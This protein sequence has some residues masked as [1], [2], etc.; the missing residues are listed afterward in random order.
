MGGLTS[1]F[2]EEVSE[3]SY[4][5]SRGREGTSKIEFLLYVSATIYLSFEKSIDKLILVSLPFLLRELIKRRS[6]LRTLKYPFS[7]TLYPLALGL[8]T[9]LFSWTG[10]GDR[11]LVEGLSLTMRS[12]LST[13]LISLYIERVGLIN[14]LKILVDLGIP[15]GIVTLYEYVLLVALTLST[16]LLTLLAARES[17]TLKKLFLKEIWR[18][19]LSSLEM[20][21]YRVRFYLELRLMALEA[22]RLG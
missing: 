21:L 13:L 8:I 20:F 2:V 11:G 9:T 22:R 19:Q 12:S 14:I 15:E 6:R 10:L 16:S 4:A 7:V 5:L 18:H 3:L 1:K 17:R